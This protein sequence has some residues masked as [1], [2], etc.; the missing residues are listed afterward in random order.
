MVHLFMGVFDMKKFLINIVIFFAIVAG[1]DS[2][3][4]KVFHYLQANKAKG[5]TE[6]EYH[7]CN[8]LSED[9]LVMGSSR[10]AHHYVSQMFA[11]SLGMTCYNGGQDGNGIVMQYGR[12]K[13]VSKHHLPKIIIYDLEP[14]FDLC[15]DDNSRYI[16][17]LKPFADDKD[18]NDFIS[19]LF[20]FE[21]YKVLSHLYRYNYKFLEI[22]SDCVRPTDNLSGYKPNFGCI[23]PEI[24]DGEPNMLK[25]DI[26][27]IDPIKWECLNNF[28]S[29]ALKLDIKVVLV[30]SPYWRGYHNCDLSLVIKLAQHYGIFFLDYSDSEIRN[31][32]DWFADSMHLNDAGAK[33]FFSDLATKL[34]CLNIL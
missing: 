18:V 11:D 21:K 15:M 6:S 22:L 9:I 34:L 5:G 7:I 1:V 28:I 3:L 20:P 27:P 29:E 14:A 13:M 33:E 19:S 16:D 12:W 26:G 4:G 24:L 23:R 10:A 32:P 31:Y 17:R 25:E 8:N 2:V 30:S